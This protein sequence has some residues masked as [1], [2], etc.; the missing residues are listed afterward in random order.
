ME[1][2]VLVKAEAGK[3][4]EVLNDIQ[5]IPSVLSVKALSGPTDIIVHVQAADHRELAELVL[6]R[7]HTIQG[8]RETDTRYVV[9]V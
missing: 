8:I 1:A 7:L 6:S 5:E 4:R 2:Y 9:E 3:V